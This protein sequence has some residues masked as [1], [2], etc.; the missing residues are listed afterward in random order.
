MH[1][2]NISKD[3]FSKL[4]KD[5]FRTRSRNFS[6]ELCKG[7]S[8]AAQEFLQESFPRFFRVPAL[9]SS[10]KS[11]QAIFLDAFQENFLK[12]L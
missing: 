5:F 10:L 1:Q 6:G 4:C 12:F 3:S 7:T 11:L 2:G 9:R 8:R